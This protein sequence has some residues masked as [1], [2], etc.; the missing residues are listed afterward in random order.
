MKTIYTLFCAPLRDQKTAEDV[1]IKLY[2]LWQED[3]GLLMDGNLGRVWEAGYDWKWRQSS[4]I[5]IEKLF[6]PNL[7]RLASVR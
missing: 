5:R 4:G 1:V 2:A 6:K 3:G 7:L